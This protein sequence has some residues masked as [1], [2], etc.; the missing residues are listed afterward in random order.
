MPT[1]LYSPRVNEIKR[2]ATPNQVARVVEA[3]GCT[4]QEAIEYLVSE[5]GDEVDA[6]LSYRTDRA[7][8]AA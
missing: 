8:A 4:Q 7:G 1:D 5:E 6:I 2:Y 3:T